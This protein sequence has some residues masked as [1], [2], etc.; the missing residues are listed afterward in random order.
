MK[1]WLLFFSIS[2]WI[3]PISSYSQSSQHLRKKKGYF[4]IAHRGG[5]I[6]SS[7]TEDSGPPIKAAITKG[8]DMIEVDLRLTKD[9]IFIIQH[10]PTFKRYYGVDKPVSSMTWN[11]ISKLRSSKGGSKVLKFEDVLKICQGKIQLMIDNKIRG[12]DSVLF[13]KLVNLLKRY[14]L[15]SQAMMIGT[16][17]STHFFTG[18][19]R[20]SCT[21]KQLE[22]NME[23]PGYSSRNYY[24]FELPKNLSVSDVE[25]AKKNH[26]PVVAI[27]NGFRYFRSD[28]PVEET[29]NDIDKMIGEGVSCFQIDSKFDAPFFY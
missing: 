24:L 27:I 10:D 4:L 3:L 2:F 5:V 23:K 11:E 19:I 12:Q 15:L 7:N 8:Y 28:N 6:D 25:W 16:E 22:S 9:S 18:K 26:I 29:R 20:L 14:K 13:S 21:R 17:E 1:K